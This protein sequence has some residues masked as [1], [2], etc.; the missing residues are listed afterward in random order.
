M[1][2]RAA[3]LA[4]AFL[5]LASSFTNAYTT[6][7]CSSMHKVCLN[8][9]GAIPEHTAAC[10]QNCFNVAENCIHTGQW[11]GKSG[12]ATNEGNPTTPT[13]N[14]ASAPKTP[15]LPKAP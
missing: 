4:V 13:G 5:T 8:G 6:D 11:A 7:E 3:I 9:C 10:S 14:P 12:T 2:L 1:R 15:A